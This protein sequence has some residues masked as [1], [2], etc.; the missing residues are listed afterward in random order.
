MEWS[1]LTTSQLSAGDVV[2]FFAGTELRFK[3][4]VA[5]NAGNAYITGLIN[6]AGGDETFTFKVY[7]DSAKMVYP[8]PNISLTVGPAS[9]YRSYSVF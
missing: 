8:V 6:M 1:P 3:G 2:G 5:I 7:D 4:A 9:Y